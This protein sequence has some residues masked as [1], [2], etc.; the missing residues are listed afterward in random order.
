MSNCDTIRLDLDAYVKGLLPTEEMRPVASH[1]ESCPECRN[2]LIQLKQ[3]AA[4]LHKWEDI[5]P[6]AG[7][8]EAVNEK[9]DELGIHDS[10]NDHQ[11]VNLFYRFR[12]ALATAAVLLLA[13]IIWLANTKPPESTRLISLNSGTLS[14]QQDNQT[15]EAATKGTYYINNDTVM[16][17]AQT[18][19]V[20]SLADQTKIEMDRQTVLNITEP[21][22]KSRG[23]IRL[24][25]GSIYLDVAKN[26]KTLY[27]ETES[28]RIKVVG[29]RFRVNHLKYNLPARPA[30]ASHSGGPANRQVPES[31]PN[32]DGFRITTVS[33]DEGAVQVEWKNS[34]Y[35][36]KPGERIAFSISIKPTR[37]DLPAGDNM[38]NKADYLLGLLKQFSEGNDFDN[39]SA[40]EAI[41][42]SFGQ[43]IIPL[44][45]GIIKDEPSGKYNPAYLSRI[46]SRVGSESL[47]P[48]LEAVMKSSKYYIEYRSAAAE[49]LL[50]INQPRGAKIL[51]NI[52]T[53][54]DADTRKLCLAT[55]HNKPAIGA[56]NT[57][58]LIKI[59]V[60]L[61]KNGE[62]RDNP[63]FNTAVE[64]LAGISDNSGLPLLYE[65][66]KNETDYRVILSASRAIARMGDK[67]DREKALTRL[68]ALAED[69][70]DLVKLAAIKTIMCLENTQGKQRLAN[71]LVDIG[72]ASSDP[73]VK[74]ACLETAIILGDQQ[75]FELLKD[76]IAQNNSDLTLQAIQKI[77]RMTSS[78]T[79][80]GFAVEMMASGYYD[81]INRWKR[82]QESSALTL[83]GQITH[84][85]EG[86]KNPRS[87]PII[88][89]LLD[90]SEPDLVLSAV[91]IL[92]NI[93][94]KEDIFTL[95]TLL[96]RVTTA[97][98]PAGADESLRAE[99]N[100]AIETLR[101][102]LDFRDE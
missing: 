70:N 98:S 55:L 97:G 86:I 88:R 89:G 47:Y 32:D 19:A 62:N 5:T 91:R 102:T 34:V 93:G 42:A 75:A 6:Q 54:A 49:T 95:R 36:V 57:A 96:I 33:V 59:L 51:L 60:N 77:A 50:G 69:K 101:T 31:V 40:A 81:L 23:N 90:S 71:R 24:H 67:S 48:E 27:I 26:P 65:L 94:E 74:L 20:L 68:Y 82:T 72:L 58:E 30:D 80:S 13:V 61:I 99:I 52:F 85:L 76:I 56:E 7:F 16:Q 22:E 14:V 64:A 2:A 92:A 3:V 43:E 35:P 45:M 66:L 37:F 78:D 25:Q 83:A 44:L 53:N 63:L 18:K 15:R 100:T 87:L 4:I 79:L 17:T 1:L 46:L 9:I 21:S 28:G 39:A 8:I 12:Y 29:T 73:K 41:L 11:E 10:I 38:A 84:S